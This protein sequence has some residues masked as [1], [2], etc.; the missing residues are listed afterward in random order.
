MFYAAI[1][2]DIGEV[3]NV[4]YDEGGIGGKSILSFL[5]GLSLY[6]PKSDNLEVVEWFSR[7]EV[8]PPDSLCQLTQLLRQSFYSGDWSYSENEYEFFVHRSPYGSVT[9]DNFKETIRQIKQKWVDAEGLLTNINEL[10]ELLVESNLE[11]TWW[12]EP[13]AT[14]TDF[15]ALSQTLSLAIKRRA[16]KVRIKFT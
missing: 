2:T 15:Q 7:L 14:E 6:C 12:Y 4:L 8:H 13:K 10:V 11:A 1:E 5:T 3:L 16:Q 9:E